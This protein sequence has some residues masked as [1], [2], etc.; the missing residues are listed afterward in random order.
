M[1]MAHFEVE[2]YFKDSADLPELSHLFPPVI[3]EN[4]VARLR[5]EPVE[6][7]VFEALSS[8]SADSS[9]GL[10]GFGLAFYLACWHFIK[11]DVMKV[12]KEFYKGEVFPRVYASSFIVLIP[13]I[14]NPQNF[15][16]FR[17][18]NL[19]NVIYKVFSKILVARLS[20]FLE[21]IIS[22]EQEIFVK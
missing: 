10:D 20:L 18:I 14:K 21:K 4:D 8:I 22:Q 1:E 11:E 17:R 13:K 16:K 3:N 7:E 6:V 15:D 5:E 19:R 12:V 9:P 2:R